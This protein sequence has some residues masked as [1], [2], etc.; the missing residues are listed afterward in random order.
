MEKNVLF[1]CYIYAPEIYPLDRIYT[2]FYYEVYMQSS[3]CSDFSTCLQK[4]TT[5][6]FKL[7]RDILVFCLIISAINQNNIYLP[8]TEL[9]KIHLSLLPGATFL[10]VINKMIRKP[11]FW[12]TFTPLFLSCPV[13]FLMK[14]SLEIGT[15]SARVHWDDRK[16][17]E[18]T[19]S[20]QPLFPSCLQLRFWKIFVEGGQG[21]KRSS[22]CP[23]YIS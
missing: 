22:L 10:T 1:Q 3:S 9:R 6:S 4:P 14:V 7:P 23:M 21:Q 16:K 17:W 12:M 13:S 8:I 5:L 15:N 19:R 18:C 11:Y 2:A 20:D